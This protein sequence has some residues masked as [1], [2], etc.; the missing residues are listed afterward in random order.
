M[1]T[2]D[3]ELKAFFEDT[4][5]DIDDENAIDT[6]FNNY[7]DRK[8]IQCLFDKLK[9][10]STER[11]SGEPSW[12]LGEIFG[13]ISNKYSV[14]TQLFPLLNTCT[15]VEKQ[16]Y[17]NYLSGY[18]G[19]AEPDVEIVVKIAE[20][21]AYIIANPD[22]LKWDRETIA[23][24]IEAVSLAY[25]NKKQLFHVDKIIANKL[26]QMLK[27]FKA[28]LSNFLPESQVYQLLLRNFHE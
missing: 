26:I 22:D 15:L 17:F 11:Y 9:S 7:S 24:G 4:I 5:F 20:D 13:G 2:S 18:F 25:L 6:F 23:L 8:V 3:R 16:V 1:V 19:S 28:Y 14:D 12:L 10:L 27:V 21:I